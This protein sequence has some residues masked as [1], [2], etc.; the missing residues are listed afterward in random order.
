MSQNAQE[1]GKLKLFNCSS[2]WETE[3]LLHP[4]SALFSHYTKALCS[5]E[6]LRFLQLLGTKCFC[7]PWDLSS[8]HTS[9]AE[10]S[11]P[12]FQHEKLHRRYHII[13]VEENQHKS[14]LEFGKTQLSVAGCIS[15]LMEI[16]CLNPFIFPF[17][18][19][20]LCALG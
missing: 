3:E 12:F 6:S 14:I 18:S 9:S 15:F 1:T 13:P 4:T 5:Y 20:L 11:P 8:F 19:I 17:F 10:P 2:L 7:T 16:K